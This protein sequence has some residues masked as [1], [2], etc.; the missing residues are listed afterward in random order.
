MTQP[1][2]RATVAVAGYF[3]ASHTGLVIDLDQ[4]LG[5]SEFA[6]PLA[7]GWRAAHLYFLL[8]SFPGNRRHPDP[9]SDDSC[10]DK[11]DGFYISTAV[12]LF[13]LIWQ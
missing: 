7:A 9:F 2:G 6:S 11:L 5:S 12:S 4:R 10:V 8:I 1:G 3:Q 13:L